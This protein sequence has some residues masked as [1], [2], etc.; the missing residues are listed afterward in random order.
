MNPHASVQESSPKESRL[1]GI[2]LAGGL[3]LRLG[4][5]KARVHLSQEESVDLLTRSVSLA[6][7]VCGEALVIGREQAGLP[8][9]PD[10]YPGCGPVGGIATAL[11]VS[12]SACLVLSCDLPFMDKK[13]LERLA[14]ERLKSPEG[15]LATAYRQQDTGHMEALVAIYEAE[16]LPFF[17]D[18]IAEGLLKISRIIPQH[19]QHF[20]PYSAEEALP[21]FNINYPADLLVARR[22]LQMLGPS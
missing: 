8:S 19:R 11:E 3:S 7:Q 12:K 17:Q 20:I 16:A 4:H 15:T 1:I 2:V 13:T 10:I 5:D 18:S 14:E 9:Y 22:V 21:F 6:R